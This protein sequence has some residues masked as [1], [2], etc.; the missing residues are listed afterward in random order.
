MQ[1]YTKKNTENNK[2]LFTE[3]DLQ[4]FRRNPNRENLG[5]LIAT[6]KFLSKAIYALEKK[7]F[8]NMVFCGNGTVYNRINNY[9]DRL[10]CFEI[11][12]ND[13]LIAFKGFQAEVQQALK[14]FD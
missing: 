12:V 4:R 3:T 7:E 6:N 2:P 13:V 11:S 14:Y 1:Y 8:P 10:H 9:I 5:F